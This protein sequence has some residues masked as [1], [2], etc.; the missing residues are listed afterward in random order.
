MPYIAYNP[1]G[2]DIVWDYVRNHWENITQII[3]IN[4][5]TL[6]RMIPNMTKRFSTAAKLKEVAY[7][8]ILVVTSLKYLFFSDSWKTSS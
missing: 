1:N 6:G 2:V 5:R 8:R 3:D 7:K 4:D